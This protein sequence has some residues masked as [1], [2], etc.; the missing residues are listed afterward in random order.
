MEPHFTSSPRWSPTTKL[1]VGLVV[2]GIIAFFVRPVYKPDHTT[3]NGFYS[4]L[5][6][7]PGSDNDFLLAA[8]FVESRC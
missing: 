4:G 1:L 2:V 3:A 8:R 7:A 6:S 5:S